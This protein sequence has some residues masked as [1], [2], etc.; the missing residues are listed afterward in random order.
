MCSA[1]SAWSRR[2]WRWLP[3]AGTWRT[4]RSNPTWAKVHD[5]I[6]TRTRSLR[7]ETRRRERL[8]LHNS[9][10]AL[11]DPADEA[12][13][14]AEQAAREAEE[15][16]EAE[17]QLAQQ[18]A[19]AEAKQAPPPVIQQEDRKW[20]YAGPDK[21]PIGPYGESEI[22]EMLMNGALNPDTF[23][24]HGVYCTT[25]SPASTV[26]IFTYTASRFRGMSTAVSP[27]QGM[28]PG[29]PLEAPPD[30]TPET[31]RNDLSAPCC[32][33]P[34]LL[35]PQNI[36][37]LSPQR[38]T[39]ERRRQRTTPCGSGLSAKFSAQRRFT[40]SFSPQPTPRSQTYV[41]ILQMLQTSW[42]EQLRSR[43]IVSEEDTRRLFGNIGASSWIC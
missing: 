7:T 37:T 38:R 9:V 32:H 26:D 25:W 34:V 35:P 41:E 22:T 31:I 36:H 8:A 10:L 21:R 42:S 5:A 27:N 13:A 6:G 39:L 40:Y 16:K 17:A 29:P 14:A 1:T 3:C 20:Y 23:V 2:T 18:A 19:E 4:A 11:S 12:A 43:K 15:A 28:L 33:F 30:T 24:W